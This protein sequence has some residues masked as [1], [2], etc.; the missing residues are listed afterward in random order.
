MKPITLRVPG[1]YHELLAQRLDRLLRELPQAP[2]WAL[3]DAARGRVVEISI[4]FRPAVKSV[5][6]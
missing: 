5:A 4:R 2:E 6:A 3:D 1:E